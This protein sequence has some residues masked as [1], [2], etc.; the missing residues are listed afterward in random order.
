MEL[1]KMYSAKRKSIST[2]CITN[3]PLVVEAVGK[4]VGL[5]SWPSALIGM[6]HKAAYLNTPCA[7]SRRLSTRRRETAILADRLQES[8]APL[9]GTLADFPRQVRLRSPLPGVNWYEALKY[10]TMIVVERPLLSPL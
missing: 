7:D 2:N 4:M 6:L 9:R 5:F 3:L 1:N 10:N 8:H